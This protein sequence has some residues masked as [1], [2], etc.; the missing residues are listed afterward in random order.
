MRKSILE[1]NY[2]FS[3]WHSASPV[4]QWDWKGIWAWRGNGFM[5]KKIEIPQSFVAQE[6]TLG[7][8]ESY[9]YN[10]I[11]INGK[12]IFSGILKG[13]RELKIVPK[14]TWKAGENSIVIK[15]NKNIEP[16]WFG[17]GFMGSAEDLFVK[18]K[19]TKSFT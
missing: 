9:S 18:S 15:M 12:Q 14:N 16:E 3:K 13:K 19:D 8:A 11:Y 1:A 5:A 17:V 10:E 7:L 2:D 4:G 6:T